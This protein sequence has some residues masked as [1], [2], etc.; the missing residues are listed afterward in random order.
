M[1]TPARIGLIAA[2]AGLGAV[3]ATHAA[4]PPAPLTI[5]PGAVVATQKLHYRKLYEAK[6]FPE[7]TITYH[8]DGTYHIVSEG[9]DHAGVYV[10]QGNFSD[11]TYTVRYISL[12]SPDWGNRTAFHQLTFVAGQD[13]RSGVFIQ[14][15]ITDTGEAI[16]QQ[17]GRYE[18]TIVASPSAAR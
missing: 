12:P 2:M 6:P 1:W 16:A 17:N 5:V 4:A 14:N 8:A 15:A 18:M 3:G 13:A 7:A 11:E 9:E 10:L